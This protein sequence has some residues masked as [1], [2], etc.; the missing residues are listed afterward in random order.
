MT[1]VYA[2][3]ATAC[4]G[5]LA[6]WFVIPWVSNV[7]L[8][9]VCRRSD[10]W[11]NESLRGYEE[12]KRNHAGVEPDRRSRGYEGALGI[13]REDAVAAALSGVLT[14]ERL[15]AMGEAGFKVKGLPSAGTDEDRVRRFSF[16]ADF[17]QQLMCA[18]G[19]GISF[20]V[21]ALLSP[22]VGAAAMLC[23]CLGAM[24]TSVVCDIRARTI[25]LE[26]CAALL[27]AGGLFQLFAVGW[28][29]LLGGTLVALV[30]TIA[31][32]GMNC[33]MRPRFPGGGIGCGDVRCMGALA[34]AT[35]SGAVCG[36]AVCY[37]LAGLVAIIGC[38]TKRIAWSDGVPMAPFLAVWL[39]AG[40]AVVLVSS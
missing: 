10:A 23:V 11:W 38:A 8:I 6:G 28:E 18:A 40:M 9:R 20:S 31:A 22:N 12:F 17:E 1:A 7:L 30:I 39:V 13:W 19:L 25:P 32:I 2:A 16:Q 34:V 14:E 24:V 21:A 35:G 33:L 15:W 26:A 37:A 4:I 36:F 3:L 27:V 5:A 29:G